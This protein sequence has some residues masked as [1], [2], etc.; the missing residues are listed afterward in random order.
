MSRALPQDEKLTLQEMTSLSDEQWRR[1][2]LPVVSGEGGYYG[3][4]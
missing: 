4:Q 1:L 2:K 3:N